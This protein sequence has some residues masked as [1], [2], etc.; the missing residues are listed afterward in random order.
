MLPERLTEWTENGWL[1]STDA[2][3]A[4][5]LAEQGGETDETVL[6]LAA[7]V[8][9]QVADGHIRLNL[10]DP[11]P[12]ND[13]PLSW[14]ATLDPTNV[15]QTLLKSTNIQSNV[16]E[17]VAAGSQPLVWNKPY[18]YLR[19]Y[20]ANEQGIKAALTARLQASAIEVP[21]LRQQLNTLFPPSSE[22]PNWQRIAC[23]LA[24]RSRFTLITGGPGTGKTRTVLRILGLLQATR[25]DTHPGQPLRIRLAAPT[26]KAA[27]RLG[28]SISAEIDALPLPKAIRQSIPQEPVTL[29]RL[30]G[31]RPNSRLFQHN[32]E[33]PLHA[34]VVV[35][36]E[37]SM[38][39]QE[40]TA[41]LLDALRPDTTLI[42]LG[43][44]DQ[45]AA[46]EAGAV[47]GE[48][49]EGA[50]AGNYSQ[51]TAQWL[52][53]TTGDDVSPWQN[54][55]GSELHQHMIK[56]RKSHRFNHDSGIG[57]LAEAI[58]LEQHERVNSLLQ[59]SDSSTGL[60]ELRHP[61]DNRLETA[62]VAGY[63]GYLETLQQKRP[64]QSDAEQ[65]TRWAREVIIASRQYQVLAVIRNGP[66]GVSGLNERIAKSLKAAR[67]ISKDRGWYE[68]RLVM[69]TR[70]DYTLDLMNGDVGIC[71]SVQLPGED[72]PRLRVAF[73]QGNHRVRF[74]LPSRLQSVES[75]FAMTVHKSQ[76]SE[77]NDVLVVLP[78][79][80][81]PQHRREVLYTAIT[82]ARA[83]SWIAQLPSPLPHFG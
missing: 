20:W 78:E 38:I 22:Q 73:E 81:P 47:L 39:D 26:G 7:I 4:A 77:F 54:E 5:L 27:A 67:L 36:D 52:A 33:N 70:N 50:D 43:D 8:S 31:R 25:H 82:R 24:S 34:D 83:S 10:T 19:R 16:S 15:E 21:R 60:L 57:A 53:E 30:L 3:F 76:G 51:A 13:G 49:C 18:L 29:H 64:T 17:Q 72:E 69:V 75:V 41:R 71:L 2:A 28:E 46:V 59:D 32:R 35:V 23:A 9:R 56:L 66:L 74:F 6:L 44:K 63:R 62:A 45:L 79:T 68:G 11:H 65:L 58:R 37:A 1:R 55:T 14:L 48:L 42:L 12:A 40:L 61:L 80:M